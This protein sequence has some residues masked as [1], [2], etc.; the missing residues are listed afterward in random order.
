MWASFHGNEQVQP[1]QDDLHGSI[2]HTKQLANDV[3]YHLSLLVPTYPVAVIIINQ[4]VAQ[5][6]FLCVHEVFQPLKSNY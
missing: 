3:N 1:A 2:L 6:A 5:I 4:T